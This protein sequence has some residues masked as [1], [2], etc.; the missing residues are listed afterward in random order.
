LKA[1]LEVRANGYSIVDE[2]LEAGLRPIAVPISTRDNRIVAA[3]NV[4]THVSR[5]DRETLLK[6][7]IPALQQGARNLRNILI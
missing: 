4:G 1:L 6:R 5:I 2:E 7:C 3:I